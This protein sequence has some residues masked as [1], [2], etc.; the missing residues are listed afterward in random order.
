MKYILPA[1]MKFYFI[2]TKNLNHPTDWNCSLIR[3]AHFLDKHLLRQKWTVII[4]S[5]YF[6]GIPRST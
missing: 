1:E 3:A 6:D 5:F 4:Y 2:Y